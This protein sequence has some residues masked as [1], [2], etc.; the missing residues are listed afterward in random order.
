[1]NKNRDCKRI[2]TKTLA[3][4]CSRNSCSDTGGKTT[5]RAPSFSTWPVDSRGRG[6][7]W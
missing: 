1:M 7:R 3:V 5:P 2:K 4:V 6:G